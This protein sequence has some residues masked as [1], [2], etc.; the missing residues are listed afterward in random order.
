MMKEY[1]I[2]PEI[3]TITNIASHSQ[4]P[5]SSSSVA[6]LTLSFRDIMFKSAAL[7]AFATAVAARKCHDLTIPISISALN[8]VYNLPTP[9]TEIDVTN[10]FLDSVR[11]GSNFGN[12]I[13]TG[14]KTVS[15]HYTIAATYCQ[16]DHGPGETLQILTHGVGFDRAYWDYPFNSHNYSYVAKAVD[17]HGYSTF[18]WDRLGVGASSKGEPINEIQQ[19]LEVAA[20]TELSTMLRK[21]SVKGIN[22]KFSR[23]VYAGHSFGSIIT[24]NFVNAN[25]TLSDAAVL[26]GFSQNA[27][28]VQGFSLGGNFKPVKEV[29]YLAAKYPAGYVATPSSIGLNIQFFGP[30]DF[31]PKLLAYASQN[32]SPA[33]IG[34]MLTVT[35]G[36]AMPNSF[37][38]HV[39]IVTGD[40]DL[41]FCGGNCSD[42]TTIQ[43]AYPNLLAASQPFFPNVSSFNAT[44][45]PGGGHGLNLGYSHKLAYNTIFDFLKSSL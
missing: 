23:Y 10:F 24:Y 33:S 2:L 11:P 3:P 42:T 39:L 37:K 25:P 30:N 1:I 16:P 35:A 27:N 15:G 9:E 26:T 12:K 38:G 13:L 36:V 17:D 7:L 29:P 41:P 31:D 4:T 43:G 40:Q 22:A 18:S 14:Q 45:I 44:V 34:E 19:F 21:G 28:F 32:G 6:I 8:N 20:L 5:L